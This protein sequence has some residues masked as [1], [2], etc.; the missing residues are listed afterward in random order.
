MKKN[1]FDVSKF[2]GGDKAFVI[3]EIGHNHR[4]SLETARKLFLEAKNAGADAVKLQKRDNRSLFTSKLYDQ[5]YD[6]PNS[7]GRTYGEHRE[8]LEFGRDEY[9]VLMAYAKVIDILFFSTPFDF[10]SLEFLAE[11][12][13]PAY[14]IASADL[15]HTP[16]LKKIAEIGKPMFLSTG[17]GTMT[18]IRRACDTI[19][20]I[21][22]QLSILH[23]T[24]A[25]PV[26][27]ADMNLNVITELL[28]EYPDQT[29]GLSDHENGIDA[30]S[31]AYIMGARVFE[32]HFTLNRSWKGTDHAFSLEPRGLRQLVRNLNRI[33]LMLGDGQKR[34]MESEKKP[35]TKMIKSIVA[36]K[37]L[38]K[39]TVL[40]ETDIDY[41]CPQGGLMP[42]QYTDVIG[43]KTKTEIT[44]EQII[45]LNLLE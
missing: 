25:Y 41:K 17:G 9:L 20:P 29:I 23:C 35:L 14:K 16:L 3:A 8:A 13:M 34:L 24:A 40:N 32:K 36:A 11:L 38:P 4:G 5:V 22:N 28:K 1:S 44:E 45:D 37:D 30:A 27:P 42:W 10:R 7:Y 6:N 39:G 19:L 15:F 12:G 26:D 33:P 21:N 43:K 2:R 31:L 18:D